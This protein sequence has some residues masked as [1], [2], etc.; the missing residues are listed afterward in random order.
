VGVRFSAPIQTDPGAYPASYTKS[1]GPFPGV[2][3]PGRGVNHS[4]PSS[5]EVKERVDLYVY[6]P[7]GPS[8]PVLGWI[9][10]Y[11]FIW[12]RT[13]T[14]S[15]LSSCDYLSSRTAISWPTKQLWGYPGSLCVC[16]GER[17]FSVANCV[18]PASDKVR[19]RVVVNK[20]MDLLILQQQEFW[21][22]LS[23]VPLNNVVFSS[24]ISLNLFLHYNFLVLCRAYRRL[25]VQFLDVIIVARLVRSLC[26]SCTSL[27]RQERYPARTTK[28][29][30]Y[31][32]SDTGRPG[33]KWWK[34]EYVPSLWLSLWLL[35]II[36]TSI[37]T[38]NV[39]LYVCPL[40]V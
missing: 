23:A 40:L 18:K 31:F 25:A 11:T 4:P 36:R 19:L 9:S 32:V 13:G 15:G 33:Q 38:L 35:L 24:V 28:G 1:T 30:I 3:R 7:C 6:S 10:T 8:W 37:F 16:G 5:A 34:T 20:V 2:K 12:L 26:Q 27:S 21:R 39:L 17:C 29:W 14:I 22:S